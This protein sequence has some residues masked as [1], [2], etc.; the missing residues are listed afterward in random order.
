MFDVRFSCGTQLTFELLTFV[1]EEDGDL[2]MLSSGSAPKHLVL[3]S[4]SASGISCE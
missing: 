3:A 1:V 2:K 4:S